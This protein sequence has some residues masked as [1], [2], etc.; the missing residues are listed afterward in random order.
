MF[1]L[2]IGWAKYHYGDPA[3]HRCV[4]YARVMDYDAKRNTDPFKC[5]FNHADPN[6]TY[7][8][9]LEPEVI[10]DG[11]VKVCDEDTVKNSEMVIP[12]Y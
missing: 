11:M 9:W 4:Q 6:S 8:L 2:G 1:R 10:Q 12:E 5:R 3:Y 7:E